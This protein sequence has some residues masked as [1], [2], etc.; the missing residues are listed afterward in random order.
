M[1]LLYLEL[2]QKMFKFQEKKIELPP[3]MSG[4]NPRQRLYT[5]L[6]ELNLR[7]NRLSENELWEEYK[8]ILSPFLIAPAAAALE[9]ATI[10]K[11]NNNNNNEENASSSSFDY[12]N[13]L[14]LI[15][16]SYREKVKELFTWIEPRL[17]KSTEFRTSEGGNLIFLNEGGK[18]GGNILD[19][20][21]FTVGKSKQP[22]VGYE[23]FRA[24]LIKKGIPESYLRKDFRG[25]NQNLVS[26]SASKHEEQEEEEEEEED[27][28]EFVTPEKSTTERRD[29]KVAIKRRA[30]SQLTPKPREK[31][32]KT[33]H[34]PHIKSEEHLKKWLNFNELKK[35]QQHK[36]QLK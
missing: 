13:Y 21:S 17:K 3:P 6:D 19:Y 1:D 5:E 35:Q 25:L 7:R 24:F 2:L 11:S 34:H 20:L 12:H 30:N 29:I 4:T 14:R 9:P 27:D 8:K 33:S 32:E 22:P 18:I 16:K 15:P 28:E 23:S 36:Q 31:V 10:I 26:S